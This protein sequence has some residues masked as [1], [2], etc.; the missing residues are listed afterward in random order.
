[1]E[2]ARRVGAF[3]DPFAEG[4]AESRGGLV[5]RLQLLVRGAVQRLV[6]GGTLT[7]DVAAHGGLLWQLVQ[8]PGKETAPASTRDAWRRGRGVRRGLQSRYSSQCFRQ[9]NRGSV[10]PMSGSVEPAE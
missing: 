1:M 5:D 2:Y 3:A 10:R 6:A 4:I 8:G 9:R 7:A